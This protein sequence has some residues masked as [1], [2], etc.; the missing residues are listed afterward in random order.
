[1]PIRLL[2]LALYLMTTSLYSEGK[3]IINPLT[4]V[5][6]K[7]VFPLKVAG[8]NVAKGGESS[9][10]EGKKKVLCSCKSKGGLPT[11]VGIPVSF[12]EPTRVIE[13]TRNPGKLIVLNGMQLPGLKRKKKRAVYSSGGV[14]G[15]ASYHVHCYE[16]PLFNL[17]GFAR[18]LVC[19]E[20]GNKKFEIRLPYLS[21]LDPEWFNEK[22]M[23]YL[24]PVVFAV[25]NPAA[26]VACT[27][28][29]LASTMNKP[30]DKLFWC[31][32]CQ[33]SLYP[34]TGFVPNYLGGLQ[35]SLLLM[36]RVIK[37]MHARGMLKSYLE[38]KGLDQSSYCE[39]EYALHPKRAQYKTQ[40][41]YP[42][43]ATKGPCQPLGKTELF[44][45]AGKS[46]PVKGEEF[47][48]IL[49]TERRCCLDPVKAGLKAGL[50]L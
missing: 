33:G 30:I 42:V 27:P 17:L 39:K 20:F 40:I 41:V 15:Y 34:L 22:L 3:M 46:F 18:D 21:E 44:W 38:K 12:W 47:C 1:M 2:L 10:L 24:N 45:G 25:S 11:F 48:Y 32:G 13:V 36:Q 8:V 50:G 49:W 31:A 6:W 37:K 26:Q 35:S 4:D 43:S 5:C 19:T 9:F 29:C 14:S 28:D 23:K 7:C 16:Y